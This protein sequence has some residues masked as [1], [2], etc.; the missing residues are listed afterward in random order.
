[1]KAI[2]FTAHGP[3]EVLR[4]EEIPTPAPQDDQVLVRVHATTVN[5]ME[6]RIF[7][8]P[9]W[10]IRLIGGLRKPRDSSV[11]F[12]LAGRVEAVGAAVTQFHPG[13]EVFGLGKGAWAE[14]VC[15]PATLLVHKPRGVSFEAAATAGVAALTAL[16]GVRDCARV[17]Q[18][19]RV[20]V[21]GAGG[22]VGTYAVQI[23][24]ALGARVD[25]V[26]GPD[27]LE[28]VQSLGAARAID[29]TREDFTQTR[30]RYDVVIVVNGSR[31]M[32][33]YRRVLTPSGTCVVLGG[34]IPRLLQAIGLGLLLRWRRGQQVRAMIARPNQADLLVL[35]GMLDHGTVIPAIDRTYPLAEAPAAVR[36]L[37]AGHARGKVVLRVRPVDV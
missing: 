21:H 10:F 13:D 1:V 18:G 8:L 32:R 24:R 4:L 14:F 12:D 28:L 15:A 22:G 34:S 9:R 35:K 2:R 5:A 3:P 30:D 7:T 33:D 25:G 16:Q 11:G 37:M 36:Y 31:R 27:N 29:Y 23:A 19:Q 6:W 17:Q 26:C 20:L